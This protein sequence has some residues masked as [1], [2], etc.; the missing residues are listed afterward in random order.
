MFLFLIYGFVRFYVLCLDL[1]LGL[2]CHFFFHRFCAHDTFND[3]NTIEY[4]TNGNI[5]MN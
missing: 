1:N 2:F 5:P 4:L 3:F